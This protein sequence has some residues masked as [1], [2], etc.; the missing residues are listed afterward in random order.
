MQTLDGLDVMLV[1]SLVLFAL[2][3][4][5]HDPAGW[6]AYVQGRGLGPF[7]DDTWKPETVKQRTLLGV[8][9]T[10]SFAWWQSVALML[11]LL[12]FGNPLGG[13]LGVIGLVF[14]T[15]QLLLALRFV[16]WDWP[17][18]AIYAFHLLALLAWTARAFAA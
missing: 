14:T 13:W 9:F 2:L 5:L 17:A 3:A 8:F 4:A 1:A 12:L 6:R 18:L 11:A 10:I 7:A 15:P 16:R